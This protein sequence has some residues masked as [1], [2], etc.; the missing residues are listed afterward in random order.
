MVQLSDR[1]RQNKESKNVDKQEFANWME[2]T[3]F[4]ERRWVLDQIRW[5]N[6]GELLWYKGGVNGQYIWIFPKTDTQTCISVGEYIGAVP[7]IMESEFTPNYAN[8]WPGDVNSASKHILERLGVE[9][10]LE[11]LC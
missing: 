6:D 11:W 10:L 4:S 2:L 5:E 8:I 7:H 9:F 3:K 1:N